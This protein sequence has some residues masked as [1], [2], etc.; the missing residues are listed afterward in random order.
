MGAR[1]PVEGPFDGFHK[2]QIGG[3]GPDEKQVKA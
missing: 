2:N 3:D 1:T